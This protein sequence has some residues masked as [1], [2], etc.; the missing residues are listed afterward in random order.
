MEFIAR[1]FS[2]HPVNSPASNVLSPLL[3]KLGEIRFPYSIGTK[4]GSQFTFDLDPYL[5]NRIMQLGGA[6]IPFPLPAEVKKKLDFAFL[7]GGKTIVVEVEKSN[8]EK[9][10]YD[11][12]KFHIYF[13]HGA[14]Y[15]L[16]FLPE[17]WPHIHNTLDIFKIGK[18]HHQQCL[19]FGFG[20]EESLGR[21]LIVGYEQVTCDGVRLSK[22]VRQELIDRHKKGG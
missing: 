9:I 17:N 4:N 19:K 5:K 10:L 11:F 3:S 16:L 8:D 14:D 15:A 6:E 12:M 21:I 20:T 22:D 7:F 2:W 1:K 13:G 18:E